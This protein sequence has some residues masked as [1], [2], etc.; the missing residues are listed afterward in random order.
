[1]LTLLKNARLYAPEPRGMCDILLCGSTVARLGQID[2]P[3]GWEVETID[4][5][6]MIVTPG[7]I[8]AHVHLLGGGGDWGLASR[9]TE[10]GFSE[11]VCEGI[12]TVVGCLGTDTL[13]KNLV[14]LLAKVRALDEEGMSAFMYS[15]G[16][17]H[18]LPTITGS[19]R[20]DIWLID[21]VIGAGEVTVSDLG[22]SG[23]SMM[24]PSY[25]ARIAVD[26]LEAGRATRKAGIVCLHVGNSGMAPLFEVLGR[27]GLPVGTFL[28]THVNRNARCFDEARKFLNLGGCVD[29]TTCYE[30]GSDAIPAALALAELFRSGVGADH[31]S[32]SSDG[33]AGM[34]V[35]GKGGECTTLVYHSVATLPH[36]FRQAVLEY[37][38]PLERALATIT[39][40]PARVHQLHQKGRVKPGADADLVVLSDGLEVQ[41][42]WVRGRRVVSAGK[43]VVSG[44]AEE[45]KSL[46]QASRRGKLVEHGDLSRS[47]L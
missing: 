1:M 41:E 19:I 7:F 43:V 12:T 24:S 10:I 33:N 26:A 23:E 20:T 39:L 5:Q 18:P 38:V 15:G 42:V 8:D 45:A 29:L 3:V 22:T 11:L 6:G 34:T 32:M 40:T 25:L 35:R 13:S 46:A 31:I 2:L 17:V 36:A 9:F 27:T 30:P 28:P 4:L 21:K 44:P 14:N 37:G 47:L 16:N